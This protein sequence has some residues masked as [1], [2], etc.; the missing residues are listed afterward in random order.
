[1]NRFLVILCLLTAIAM[2]VFTLP[3]GPAALV[4][5]LVLSSIALLI[6]RHY[7][8]DK[9]F[10]TNIFLS[11]LLLRVLFGVVIHI[12][13]LREFVGP[14]SFTYDYFGARMADVWSGRIS[15]HDPLISSAMVTSGPGWGMS[16]L[17]G[18]IY[19]VIGENMFAAQSF[20]AVFGAATAPMIYFCSEKIFHNKRVA[21]IA[22]I[23]IT[24]FP[25]FIIWSSQLL[26]DGLIIFL[27]VLAMTMVLQLQEKF[28]YMAALLLV[29]SLSGIMALRFYIFY[30]VMVAVAG[31]FIVGVSNTAPAIARRTMI[32]VFMGLALTYLGVIRNATVDFERFG[33]LERV[34]ISRL[35]LARSA[36]SGLDENVDVS[37][38]EG[39]ILA[40]PIGFAYLM[41]APF[42]WQVSNFR[43]SITLPEV[44]LWWALIP[45]AISGLWYTVRHR[46]RKAFPI[47]I[48]GVMLTLA[49][50]IFQG[51][52]GTAYRQRTQIQ[53]FMFIFI[54]VGW[55][56]YQ[57]K[58]ENRKYLRQQKQT[59]IDDALRANMRRVRESADNNPGG[60]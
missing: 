22:A 19:S 46:L 58:K 16:Y 7:A 51:N 56:L 59:K 47:L 5:V 34:Q 35:D 57:E 39:A 18:G 45:L 32:L 26:K 24:L 43:Q 10:I 41:F 11:A 36:E 14:D 4:V 20:C 23:S 54:A 55:S 2:I 33:S 1:M 49:Y 42:P 3:H 9:D 25:A 30:M 15:I 52:V 8:D 21:K 60:E 40:I 44:L 27:L 48:F 38:A 29:F 53:V 50:S 13:E 37:T 12:F 31:S 6:F 17:V 28:N